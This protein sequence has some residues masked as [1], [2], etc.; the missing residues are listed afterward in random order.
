MNMNSE[1]ERLAME[2]NAELMQTMLSLCRERTIKKSHTSQD[3]SAS[4]KQEFQNC[5]L[6][7]H[8]APNH[9]MSV[10]QSMN[11]Q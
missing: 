11:M 6:K 10:A 4:E 2:M 1:E 3:L 7:F 5:I 9:I 8:E